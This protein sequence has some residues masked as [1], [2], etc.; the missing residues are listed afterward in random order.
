MQNTNTVAQVWRDAIYYFPY[1][2]ENLDVE[3]PSLFST[4]FIESNDSKKSGLLFGNRIHRWASSTCFKT[5]TPIFQVD[6]HL[7]SSHIATIKFVFKLQCQNIVIVYSLLFFCSLIC[8][9]LRTD[10]AHTLY[11]VFAYVFTGLAE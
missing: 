11:F 1:K 3:P 6:F 5:D 9:P 10:I 4:H 7:L 2:S 8:M